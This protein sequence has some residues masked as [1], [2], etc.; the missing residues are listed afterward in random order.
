MSDL[1]EAISGR[2][3]AWAKVKATSVPP[4]VP[5]QFVWPGT[6]TIHPTLKRSVTIP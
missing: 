5:R 6:I 4:A 2:P 3:A 1:F